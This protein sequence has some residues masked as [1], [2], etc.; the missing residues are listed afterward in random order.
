MAR[1]FVGPSLFTCN[2]PYRAQIWG[3]NRL[4]K[5]GR[6]GFKIASLRIKSAFIHSSSRFFLA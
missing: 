1:W 2:R 6:Y 5:G 3:R 4:L